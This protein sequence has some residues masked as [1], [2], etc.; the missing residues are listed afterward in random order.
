MS[1][2]NL[3]ALFEPKT[4]ALVGASNRPNSVGAVLA[5]NLLEAGFAGPILPVNPKERAIRST[6]C[7][8]AIGELPTAPDLAVLSTPPETVPGLIAELGQRGCK[9]AIV[10]TA[11]F[12][13]GERA[14]GLAL[15][16]RLLDAA[17]PHLLRIVGPNCLGLLSPPTG[18][19]A[20]FAHVA[21]GVGDIAFITQ[22]GAIATAVLDFAA[23][24]R[25]GFSRIVSLGSMAD[26]D[27]GDLLDYLALDKATRSILLYIEAVT[28]ARKFLS[29]A[30]TASRSKPVVVIK[31]GRSAAG[32]KAALSH[33]GAL[34]GSDSVYDAVF[35]RAGMLRVET[36][37]ELFLAVATLATAIRIDGDRLA[38]LTN[39]GGLG[40]LAADAL[41][42]SVGTLATLSP[43][44]IARL[45]PILPSAWS[46]ANPVDI[47]GDAPG[48]R[49]AAALSALLEDRERDA[50]LVMN[51]PTAVADSIEGAR[52]VVDTLAAK[53]GTPVLTC[54]L[55]EGAAVEA[56]RLFSASGLPTYETPEQA[57][58]AFSYLV[59]YRRNQ[60][61]LMETPSSEAE[62]VKTD[63]AAAE[64]V[65]DAVLADGR[66]AL[67]QPEA[68]AVLAAYDIPTVPSV[69]A[70]D[71]AGARAAAA[72]MG[73]P[74]V[75]KILSRDILHKSDVGG[76]Q[77]NLASPAAVGQA[78]EDMLAAVARVSP[79][80]R[81]D[82][83]T[84]QPMIRR[85]GATELILGI[86]QDPVF[87]PVILF[88]EGGTAVEVIAD[89]TVG[90]PPLNPI[91]ARGMIEHTRVYRRLKGYRDRPPADLDAIAM[92][93]VKLSQ[94]ACDLDRVVELDINPLIADASG[95]IGLD[96]RIL[97]K[98]RKDIP[99]NRLAIRPYP[100]T[101]ERTATLRDGR[102]FF[103]RPIKPTD[104]ARVADLLRHTAPEA[105]RLRLFA[106]SHDFNSHFPARLTQIDY[107]R[108]MALLAIEPQSDEAFGLVRLLCDPDNEVAEFGITVRDEMKG[109]GLGFRLMNEI[110]AYARWRGVKRIVGEVL[111]GNTTM[112][113]MAGELGFRTDPGPEHVKVTLDLAPGAPAE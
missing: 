38:I 53:P 44:T 108:E 46:R 13:E 66:S 82:G 18:I 62:D 65:I 37:D 17:R 75:L 88:G 57:I 100:R 1:I 33:T 104:E 7:Y 110:I 11:G 85:S 68:G 99:P 59:K 45:D 58:S 109:E 27:F 3:N 69:T 15:R 26:V 86:A 98:P 102:A 90:L 55:G 95:V 74:V 72:R 111:P 16:Q 94:L 56:R 47:I 30:R 8:N 106:P 60:L 112:L 77:V 54:W 39:G 91:L 52:A 67:T 80:A 51:C 9:A 23:A 35:R 96:A 87:G 107:D 43:E 40:V 71:P 73:F 70:P 21:P 28:N 36:L 14:E 83:F 81:I 10:I 64:A 34:A 101:L 29:A 63:V 42:E 50:I 89:R 93:L 19:N 32:A 31:A 22:S 6:L 92:T 78:A 5:R 4:I 79:E 84:V 2:R 24:R 25:I 113:A 61:S 49:Y 76:V 105:L 12:G 103:L 41:S 48:A 97:V 20:S